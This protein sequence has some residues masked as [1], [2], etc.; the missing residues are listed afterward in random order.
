MSADATHR[1]VVS[2]A[3]NG[4]APR[5]PELPPPGSPFAGLATR[6]L[7]G[8]IDVLI[9]QAVAWTVGAVAA[10]AASML[11]FSNDL[12]AILI[13][14]G[15]VVAALWSAGYFVFFWSTTGQTPGDRVMEIRVQDE[16]DG[17][18]LHFVRAVL[19]LLGALLSALLL[20]LGYLMILVDDRRRALHD[21]LVG[22]VVVFA[23]SAPRRQRGA[24]SL[25][26]G[27]RRTR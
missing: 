18:P 9:I 27:D 19:R 17:R 10:V 23:P 22:S 12:E 8:V 24:T 25:N 21:R 3:T 26:H 4:A 2:P 11:D 13:G 7:A 5:T 15:V 1:G 20:F 6:V 16:A 14:A